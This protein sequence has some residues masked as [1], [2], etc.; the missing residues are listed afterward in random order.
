MRKSTLAVLAY[1]VVFPTVYFLPA[2]GEFFGFPN[3]PQFSVVT[4]G[5]ASFLVAG[6]LSTVLTPV[7]KR[8][9]EWRKANGRDIEAEE[10][11]ETSSGMIR[12]TPND[13]DKN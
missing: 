13:D 1:F 9:L 12:L 11:F 2:L 4:S 10:R 8:I 3:A 7:N 5:L 6:L